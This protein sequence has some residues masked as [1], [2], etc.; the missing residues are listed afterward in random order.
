MMK[1]GIKRNAK[2]YVTSCAA[3]MFEHY[4]ASATNV[5]QPKTSRTD[6]STLNSQ[7][8]LKQRVS[9]TIIRHSLP[10]VCVIHEKLFQLTTVTRGQSKNSTKLLCGLFLSWEFR[11]RSNYFDTFPEISKFVI[12]R[13]IPGTHIADTEN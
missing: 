1:L 12:D 2:S 13:Y 4:L 7:L 11:F 5:C 6:P 10:K 9:Y 3:N 8:R